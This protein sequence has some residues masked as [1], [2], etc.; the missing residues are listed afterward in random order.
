MIVTD[1][2]R[3]QALTGAEKTQRDA[4]DAFLRLA[5][6][7]FHLAADAEQTLRMAQLDDL[8][9]RASEQWPDDIKQQ[10]A[11]D[12]RPCLTVNRLTQFVRQVTN[13]ARENKP[14]V[15][16]SPQD[17]KADLKT[18]EV[19]QGMIRNIE[20]N[21]RAPMV[22]ATAS[23]HQATIGR[24]WIRILTE[25]VDERS[26][27]QKLVL[28]RVRNPFTIYFDPA[29]QELD[30]SD[31]TFA[32][33][34]SDMRPE[35]FKAE[36]GEDAYGEGLSEFESIGDQ[37]ADWI[38]ADS[39]I[40]VAEYWYTTSIK[41]EA[42]TLA[43]GE[44]VLKSEVPEQMAVK[45]I[46][47]GKIAFVQGPQGQI[48][49]VKRRTTR[50]IEVRAATI[51]G[52]RILEGDED[53]TQGAI[54]PGLNIP[55]VPVIGDEIDI[56]GKVDYR[57]IVRD[58]KDPQ[59][60][61]NYS[62]S[63]ATETG[64]LAPKSPYVAAEGQLEGR[65]DMWA[66][67]NVKNYSTLTYKPTSL[68]GHLVPPPQ[69]NVSEPPIQ[70]MVAL[71]AQA[72]NDLKSVTGLFDASLGAPGPEQ[73]GKAIL[74]RQQQGH[75]GNVNYGD[76]LNFAIATVGRY[77]VDLIPKVYDTPQV[78][79][80][81]GIDDQPKTVMVAGKNGPEADPT[82]DIYN[83]GVGQYDV[84]VSVG[85]SYQSRRQEAT[86]AMVQFVQAYP[87]SF[88][89]IGDLLAKHMDWPGAMAISQRLAKMLPPQLQETPEGGKPPLPPEVE[90]QMGQMQEQLKMLEQALQ[91]A[92]GQLQSQQIQTAS[93]ERL[94]DKDVR[95]KLAIA[96]QEAQVA[97]EKIQAESMAV[98]PESKTVPI[99]TAQIQADAKRDIATLTAQT[100]ERVTQM[101][102]ESDERIARLEAHMA[103]LTARLSAASRVT[104]LAEGSD[105]DGS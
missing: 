65:E 49:I 22:Y 26:D 35:V 59:R 103:E 44:A 52:V 30:Y 102:I 50:R 78:M 56:N 48:P 47:T 51:S 92:Q 99:V 93:A 86:A 105:S 5:R 10:R 81:L 57:G 104:P 12:G 53:K 13:Q 29:C 94:K 83:V 27:K 54:W 97:R 64:A 101:K 39:A 17:D 6:E 76:N 91:A 32:F 18:A 34:V 19:L 3:D 79:R 14:A 72:D 61:Y 8:H 88:P 68:D 7:R 16:V 38:T 62:V 24:G 80:I 4:V 75:L 36:Y 9:F 87:N 31:A 73:S 15:L 11:R 21:S 60:R 74:A 63:A 67:A 84:T 89:M 46:F 37:R 69:R 2:P 33:V 70:A 25:Y 23:D 66:Q 96:D 28:K 55:I 20:N 1:A 90:Q 43:T 77:L 41:D 95:A 58:A 45:D 40:R 85:P 98:T 71:T 42:W 82:K 100:Q